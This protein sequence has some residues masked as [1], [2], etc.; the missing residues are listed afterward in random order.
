MVVA[1]GLGRSLNIQS[2][3]EMPLEML[4]TIVVVVVVVEFDRCKIF[5]VSRNSYHSLTP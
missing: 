4:Y 5:P 1:D 2:P 3:V